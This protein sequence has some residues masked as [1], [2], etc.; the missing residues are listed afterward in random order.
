MIKVTNTNAEAIAMA[1]DSAQKTVRQLV[2]RN[3]I[4][5]C[6]VVKGKIKSVYVRSGHD[7]VIPHYCVVVDGV[8]CHARILWVAKA[9]EDVDGLIGK[10]YE[11]VVIGAE[12]DSVPSPLRLEYG[13]GGCSRIEIE[14]RPIRCWSLAVCEK[15]IWIKMCESL[16]G[17]VTHCVMIAYA[18]NAPA[19][20]ISYDEVVEEQ[21]DHAAALYMARSFSR[22]DLKLRFSRVAAEN[23][24]YRAQVV[25][26]SK[27]GLEVDLVPPILTCHRAHC[28]KALKNRSYIIPRK[29]VDVSPV[30]R[31]E[32]Y[33][34]EQLDVKVMGISRDRVFF[35]HRMIQERESGSK[36][37]A[38]GH[39]TVTNGVQVVES[40]NA[41][42][43]PKKVILDGKN[44][45]AHGSRRKENMKVCHVAYLNTLIGAL[46]SAHVSWFCFLD[47]NTPIFVDE[48]GTE[49][50]KCLYAELL[51]K[52]AD[53]IV[54]VNGG[55][56]AD[57][58]ILFKADHER[59]DVISCDNFQKP[60]YLERYPWLRIKDDAGRYLDGVQRRVHP[61]LV[62]EGEVVIQSLGISAKLTDL[63]A[64][65]T[66]TPQ[67]A[68][69]GERMPILVDGSNIIRHF[70]NL[71]SKALVYLVDGLEANGYAP[72]LLFD[73]DI[74]S[75]LKDGGDVPGL[76]LL[77]RME[78]ERPDH[79]T[80]L[81]S[82]IQS[83]D[84][85][86]LL[87]ERRDYPVVTCRTFGPETLVGH[88]WLK[89][90]EAS[91]DRRLHVPSFVLGALVIPTL[92]IVWPVPKT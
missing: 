80:V 40:G 45:I 24:V 12:Y 11:F 92:G 37:L 88:P 2:S 30:G 26:T 36:A 56:E 82:G 71:C 58:D 66:R 85:L 22:T 74:R 51:A 25:R 39:V 19:W 89:N 44:I 77:E 54:C 86:L 23:R 90:R 3:H 81:T 32:D 59:C 60:R 48:A 41:P 47:A 18:T 6:S 70:A 10:E 52:Y 29:H 42:T 43:L 53:R 5:M 49:V 87:A 17:R 7:C 68:P 83:G 79:V 78:R 1:R 16:L 65:T 67:R 31:L 27:E 63:V 76:E 38:P 9:G 13:M 8:I 34:G 28:E 46:E 4:R 84:Y 55:H 14:E 72:T 62:A 61:F 35:S 15:N 91:R 57:D 73:A 64:G 75:A 69:E 33:L 21:S 20:G 50:D